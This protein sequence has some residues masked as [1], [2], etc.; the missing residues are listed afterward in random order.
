L[1]WHLIVCG[2]R[3]CEVTAA[4]LGPLLLDQLPK[5][6]P[7]TPS[8]VVQPLYPIS[9]SAGEQRDGRMPDGQPAERGPIGL[10]PISAER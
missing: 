8:S 7:V 4:T 5:S 3:I 6:K 9:R 2:H 10:L 1:S